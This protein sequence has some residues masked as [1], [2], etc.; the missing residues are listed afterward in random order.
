MTYLDGAW[1]AAGLAAAFAVFLLVLLRR[2]ARAPEVVLDGSNVMHWG[3]D[4]ASLDTVRAVLAEVERLGMRAGVVFDAN[5]GWKLVGRYV[6]DAE[7]ARLLGLPR[8]RVL[9]VPKGT[10]AD[11]TILQAARDRR[12][13]VVTND[14][15]RDWA[16]DF[17]EV[18]RPGHLLRGRV[19]GGTVALRL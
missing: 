6:D 17:P 2:R 8:S 12:A 5:A 7:M 16:G 4:G 14:R 3:G 1:L 18:A 9:V 15:F 10:S 11:P 13:R 19:R